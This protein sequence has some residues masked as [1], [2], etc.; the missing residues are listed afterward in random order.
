[1]HIDKNFRFGRSKKVTY[2]LRIRPMVPGA[3][4]CNMTLHILPIIPVTHVLPL[5]LRP[6]R[7]VSLHAIPPPTP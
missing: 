1:M 5:H 7:S 3:Q 4:A 6:R 2:C